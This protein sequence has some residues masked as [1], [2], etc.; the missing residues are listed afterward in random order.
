MTN[1]LLKISYK[2]S[3]IISSK[4]GRRNYST[5]FIVDFEKVFTHWV[6]TTAEMIVA[7]FAF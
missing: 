7:K 5:V 2:L 3:V 6:I 4:K 1:Y